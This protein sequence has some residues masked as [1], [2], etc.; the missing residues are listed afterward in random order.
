MHKTLWTLGV[1]AFV[2]FAAFFIVGFMSDQVVLDNLT[3]DALTGAIQ[4]KLNYNSVSFITLIIAGV[5]TLIISILLFSKYI[6]K[7]RW[8]T[9]LP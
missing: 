9:R 7:W 6:A 4:S 2:A 8:T 5:S 3:G 1:I